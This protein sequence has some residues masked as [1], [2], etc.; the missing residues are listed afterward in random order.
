MIDGM[1]TP[2]H[3]L[4]AYPAGSCRRALL[5][6]VQIDLKP[7]SKTLG[8]YGVFICGKGLKYLVADGA[9]KRMQVDAPGACW[10]DADE[11]HLGLAFGRAGRSIA[12]NGMTDD[13]R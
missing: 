2:R 6:W 5:R 13:R 10:L 7:A 3:G 4:N 8:P 1:Q 12:A 9:F 11:H